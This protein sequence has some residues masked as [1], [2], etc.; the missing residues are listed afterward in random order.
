MLGYTPCVWPPPLLSAPIAA[1]RAP[2]VVTDFN[3]DG[4]HK[5]FLLY[6]AVTRLTAIWRLNKSVKGIALPQLVPMRSAAATT[7]NLGISSLDRLLSSQ[8]GIVKRRK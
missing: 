8:Y 4:C 3:G 7:A 6:S 2:S 1:V 5:L